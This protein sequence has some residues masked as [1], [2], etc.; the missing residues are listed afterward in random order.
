MNF[1]DYESVNKFRTNIKF[2]DND[3]LFLYIVNKI[4]G[5]SSLIECYNKAIDK[6]AEFCNTI[7]PEAK[8]VIEVRGQRCHTIRRDIPYKTVRANA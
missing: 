8:A 3:K 1:E 2:N 5:A 4:S 7:V 6:I